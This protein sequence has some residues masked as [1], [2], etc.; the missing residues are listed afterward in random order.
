MHETER[1]CDWI[2]VINYVSLLKICK[3]FY[4]KF[5]FYLILFILCLKFKLNIGT[6][7]L[8]FITLLYVTAWI[9]ICLPKIICCFVWLNLMQDVCK[10]ALDFLEKPICNVLLFYSFNKYWSSCSC[11]R[12]FEILPLCCINLAAVSAAINVNISQFKKIRANLYAQRTPLAFIL[13]GYSA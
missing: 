2:S 5:L 10:I 8:N 7:C 13:H 9:A 1:L 12:K 6:L 3:G 4:S 11:S